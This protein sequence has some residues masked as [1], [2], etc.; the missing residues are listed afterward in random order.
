MKRF[1][2]LLLSCILIGVILYGILFIRPYRVS[3]N[4]MIPT[5]QSNAIILIDT[6][7]ARIGKL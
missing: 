5:L 3:G 1:F 2:S 6:L 4:S 7:Q